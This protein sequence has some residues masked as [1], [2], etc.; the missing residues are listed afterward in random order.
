MPVQLKTMYLYLYKG[1]T[2]MD[3]GLNCSP[4]VLGALRALS[5]PPSSLSRSIIH[6]QFLKSQVCDFFVEGG[7]GERENQTRKKSCFFSI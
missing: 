1:G 7:G 6:A 2:D 5:H 3:R 4:R